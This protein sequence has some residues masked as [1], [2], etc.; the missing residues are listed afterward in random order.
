MDFNDPQPRLFSE[1]NQGLKTLFQEVQELR[2]IV[3]LAETE[4]QERRR[5][6]VA[7]KKKPTFIME[8]AAATWPLRHNHLESVQ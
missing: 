8:A 7:S 1:Q 4:A 6:K 3:A 5:P 2:R